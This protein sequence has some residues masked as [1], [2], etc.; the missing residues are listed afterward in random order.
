MHFV[1]AI[2]A[3]IQ[4]Q[5]DSFPSD[6][7][8]LLKEQTDQRVIIKLNIHVGNISLVDQFEWDLAEEKNSPEDF[9]RKLCADLSL[10]GEFVSAIAYSI[11]GQVRF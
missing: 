3:A 9:A 6:G 2:A 1:P 7:D 4:Q 8:N 11:R 5:L 10:G